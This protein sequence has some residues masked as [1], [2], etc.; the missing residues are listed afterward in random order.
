MMKW[1]HLTPSVSLD[2]NL[3][4]IFFF[5]PPLSLVSF[6]FLSLE[7]NRKRNRK[8]KVERDFSHVSEHGGLQS[9]E[10]FYFLYL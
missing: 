6:L 10:K 8:N 1:Y 3:M 5:F 2:S 9:G 7:E 4:T